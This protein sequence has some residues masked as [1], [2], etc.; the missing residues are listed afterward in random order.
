MSKLIVEIP[1]T[2]HR[3][4]KIEAVNRGL[5]LKQVVFERLNK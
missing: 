2:L 5:T 1:D 3:D 4:L